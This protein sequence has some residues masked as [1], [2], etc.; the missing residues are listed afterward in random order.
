M[1]AVDAAGGGMISRSWVQFLELASRLSGDSFR[2]DPCQE[3]KSGLPF[4]VRGE[5]LC[6]VRLGK[7][8]VEIAAAESELSG[9]SAFRL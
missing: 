3:H 9:W 2:V 6:Y 7:D 8:G 1:R 5:P 4:H